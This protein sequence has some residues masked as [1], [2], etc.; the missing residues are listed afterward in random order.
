MKDRAPKIVAHATP[1]D[2][3]NE[4]NINQMISRAGGGRGMRCNLIKIIKNPY[5]LDHAVSDVS[6]GPE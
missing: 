6:C 4:K 3:R 2:R 1:E 5:G